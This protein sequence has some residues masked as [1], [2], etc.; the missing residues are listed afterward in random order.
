MHNKVSWNLG[1]VLAEQRGLISVYSVCRRRKN[2]RR[3][4]IF[5]NHM[6]FLNKHFSLSIFPTRVGN[7]ETKSEVPALRSDKSMRAVIS[8]CAIC[9]L[10][11][12]SQE[13]LV[14]AIFRCSFFHSLVFHSLISREMAWK[15]LLQR[16]K[17]HETHIWAHP[18]KLASAQG[19]K[20]KGPTPR[21]PH[22]ARLE[23]K[24]SH[25]AEKKIM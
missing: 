24:E 13:K 1:A 16:E 7:S 4:R 17:A 6:Y 11:R 12:T 15:N 20:E 22:F 2:A 19:L 23:K 18:H 14:I 8:C 9:I 21:S 3:G 5:A 25:L 10:C